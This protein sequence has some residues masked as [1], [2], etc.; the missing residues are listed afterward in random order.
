[1]HTAP[2]RTIVLVALIPLAAHAAPHRAPLAPRVAQSARQ[3]TTIARTFDIPTQPLA[4][5]LAEYARQSG[6]RVVATRETVVGR[7]SAALS[8]S[9]TPEVALARLLA[10]TGLVARASELGV[11]RVTAASTPAAQ[12]LDTVLVT[13]RSHRAAGYGVARSSTATRTNT[14]LL[15]TPQAVSVVTRELIADQAMQSMAD[16]V[17]YVPGVSMGL[18]E[19]H[20]DAPTIRG[21]ASTADFFVDGVRDDAQYLRDL[22]NADRVEALKG[23][24][25]MT[26]GRGGGGGV[27]NR[28]SKEAEWTRTRVLTAEGGS[29]DHRRTTLDVGQALAAP[30]AARVNGVYER[31]GGFR[32]AAAL[33]RY[34]VNPTA[35]LSLGATTV[36][37][38][39]E[40]FSDRR[41]V[42]RGVPSFRG[43]PAAVPITA[44]F[45]NPDVNRAS[46]RVNALQASA[47]R[48]S[49]RGVTVRNR[50]RLADYDKFYQNSYPGAVDSTG[51]QVTLAAYNHA[52]R[53][54]NLFN[55]TD[56]TFDAR[57]GSIGHT[58]LA[59][60]ELARQSTDQVRNTGYFGG[61]ATSLAVPLDAAAVGT[62]VEFRQSA[63]DA[64]NRATAS[65]AS[66]YAQ[67]QIELSPRWQAILGLRYERFGIRYVNDRTAQR[68]ARTD[69]MLSPR[70]GL[71]FNP[72]RSASLY[73][74]YGRSYL[75][76]SGDQFTTLT[77][78]SSTLAPERFTNYEV[79][80]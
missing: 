47:E 79:G 37:L 55:Q 27:L 17:R 49:A 29:F 76:S 58:L 19:G 34:G 65:A 68:L 51:A 28:V 62:A 78:T 72:V 43:A 1:M 22:Y 66:V 57:T 4:D 73:G 54:H 75:P 15:D 24:N 12:R 44:F 69:R 11:M 38:G 36:R 53:R 2:F 40:L 25:A 39:Y 21:N 60:V 52:I 74:G 59:G 46:A 33:E 50:T 5:A 71:V 67:D 77:V 56:L 10:G 31:S 30:V 70:A 26:F 42:D 80:A 18:G 16:V 20:R 48:T 9:F 32:D 41:T 23:A 3:D 8:G 35:A 14:P 13:A 63:T 45:G 64:D 6:V 7:R 61:T